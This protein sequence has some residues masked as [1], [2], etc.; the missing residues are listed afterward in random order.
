[1]KE[2]FSKEESLNLIAET[3]NQAKQNIARKGSFYFLLWGWVVVFCH[4]SHY[5]LWRFELYDSPYVVW[6]LTIPTFIASII[7]SVKASRDTYVRSYHGRLCGL[8]W[9]AVAIGAILTLIFIS[10][11]VIDGNAVIL[12]FSAVGTFITGCMLRFTPLI[13]GSI[14]LWLAGIVAFNM[15]ILDQH[16]VAAAG[17][18]SGYIIPG[19]LLKK[20][21]R[22]HL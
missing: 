22:E 7:Y 4:V 3:I 13:L 8:V 2:Q 9:S 17:I 14:A 21:E 10:D 16:Y 12:I 1:M 18:L 15:P 5:V 6:L 20:A 19:Y 11:V